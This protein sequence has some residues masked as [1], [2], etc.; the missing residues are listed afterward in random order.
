[1]FRTSNG[2]HLAEGALVAD[3]AAGYGGGAAGRS[4]VEPAT[5]RADASAGNEGRCHTSA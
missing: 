5:S 1:M 4:A 3:Y 2:A